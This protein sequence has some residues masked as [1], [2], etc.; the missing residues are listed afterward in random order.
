M[1]RS[2]ERVVSWLNTD[3]VREA[4]TR[5]TLRRPNRT[6]SSTI[7]LIG[8]TLLK[9][10]GKIYFDRAIWWR[11]ETA[12]SLRRPPRLDGLGVLRR[13]VDLI[14]KVWSMIENESLGIAT[15]LEVVVGP[16]VLAKALAYGL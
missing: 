6:S 2:S 14:S 1:P 3:R 15:L 12:K 10:G 13:S 4:F 8:Y 16:L 5:G 9:P 11:K 7:S